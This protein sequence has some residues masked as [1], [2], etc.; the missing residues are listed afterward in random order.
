M[1]RPIRLFFVIAIAAACAG[2][3]QTGRMASAFPWAQPPAATAT[4]QT[5]AEAANEAA[6]NENAEKK[7]DA[8]SEPAESTEKATETA[9]AAADEK[10]DDAKTVEEK[11]GDKPD[12]KA[13]EKPEAESEESEEKPAEEAAE[14]A[15]TPGG[16]TV[17]DAKTLA[18]IDEELK[19]AAPEERDRLF[20]EWKSIDSAMV[21]QVIRIRRM[22]RELDAASPATVASTATL[23]GTT[24]PWGVNANA[25]TPPA[26][27]DGEEA[28]TALLAIGAQDVLPAGHS[29]TASARSGEATAAYG[30]SDPAAGIA[31][32]QLPIESSNGTLG[33][34]TATNSPP[35]TASPASSAPV[36][37]SDDWDRQLQQLIAVAEANAE[38]A[39]SELPQPGPE[40]R[41]PGD[42][43]QQRY[44]EAQVHLRLLY[45]MAGDQGRAMQAIPD[46]DAADQQ[47]WQQM[48]W[49]VSN[50]FDDAAQP[51]RADRM[52][53]TVDQLRTAVTRLQGEANLQLRNVAFC[54]KITSFGNFE[55]FERDEYSPG[56]RV[57]LYSEVVNF[58]SVP[59]P[60][61]GFYRTKLTSTVEILRSGQSQPLSKIE[62]DPTVDLCRSYRQDYFHSY[63]LKIPEQL[64]AG[65]YVLKLTV[66]D[67]HSGKLATYTLNFTVK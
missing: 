22:V 23:A 48:L 53:Q 13:D 52:S 30:Q 28:T 34:T 63:E 7:Q 31:V 16:T 49:G 35:S 45:L 32:A 59:Q 50:Y 42:P 44:V 26:T 51:N 43:A 19:L 5:E 29:Q 60:S 6:S 38:K 40:G 41:P 62:F 15:E 54:R 64:N 37:A 4:V 17:H 47:F 14:T 18:L 20:A 67:N 33:G 24:S 25:A 10:S 9:E 39:R 11:S 1:C 12:E 66:E 8:E 46:L 21:Q 58:K 2:C 27:A 3:A 55:Q 65:D 56:Q 57:L 61:D 36:A